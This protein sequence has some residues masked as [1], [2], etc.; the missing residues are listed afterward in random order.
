MSYS[1]LPG[2][3]V[4]PEQ[5]FRK[6]EKVPSSDLCENEMKSNKTKEKIWRQGN[7]VVN[8]LSR[9]GGA[10]TRRELALRIAVAVAACSAAVPAQERKIDPTWLHRN[11]P[12]AKEAGATFA[13][14]TCHY[15]PMFGEGSDEA[16]FCGVYR[17]SARSRSTLMAT[18]RASLYDREE[19]IYFVVQGRGLLNYGDELRPMRQTDFT[20]SPRA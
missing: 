16:G 20:Y 18:A 8:E 17:A 11:L 13:I 9:V 15:K 5:F 3:E 7:S 10:R 14:G 2:V 12:E 19:E 1:S 4:A 6:I